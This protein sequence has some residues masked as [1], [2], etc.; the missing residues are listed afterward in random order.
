MGSP[1][2]LLCGTEA[3][4]GTDAEEDPGDPA[5]KSPGK[6]GCHTRDT[7]SAGVGWGEGSWLWE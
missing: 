5:M 2:I 7:G 4:A 3:N 6:G 1:F